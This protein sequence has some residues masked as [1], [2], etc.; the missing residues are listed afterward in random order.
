MGVCFLFSKEYETLIAAWRAVLL[1]SIACSWKHKLCIMARSRFCR[2]ISAIKQ[3]A[4]CQHV[5]K[6]YPRKLSLADKTELE[7]E[8]SELQVMTLD[9]LGKKKVR[10]NINA[11]LEIAW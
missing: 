5:H 1:A 8:S 3:L 4:C 9:F 10:V 2:S 7:R 6:V 11:S